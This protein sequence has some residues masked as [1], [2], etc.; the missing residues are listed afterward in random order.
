MKKIAG[1]VL[2]IVGVIA[3]AA[4]AVALF[5][6][7]SAGSKVPSNASIIGGADGPTAIFLAGELGMPVY[8]LV[9]VGAVLVLAGLILILSK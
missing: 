8:I 6:V 3:L 7:F 2:L 1:I 4:G 9:I 5:S